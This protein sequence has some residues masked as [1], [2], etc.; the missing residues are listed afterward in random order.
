MMMEYFLNVHDSTYE[1]FCIFIID[2]F[3][4]SLKL[5]Y[6]LQKSSLAYDYL[7]LDFTM[8]EKFLW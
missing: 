7:Y 3:E 5:Q 2:H 8:Y 6:F 4:N 1:Q